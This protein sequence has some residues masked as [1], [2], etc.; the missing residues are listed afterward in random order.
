MNKYLLIFAALVLAVS[1]CEGNLG[2]DQD[3]SGQS[4]SGQVDNNDG[5]GGS[6]NKP[7]AEGNLVARIVEEYIYSGEEND[8][9]SRN[10][11]DFTY[12]GNGNVTKITYDDSGEGL[13]DDIWYYEF[14]YDKDKI[15]LSEI[16]PFDPGENY[17]M[18]FRLDGDGNIELFEGIWSDGKDGVEKEWG[19]VRYDSEGYVIS[20]EYNETGQTP[21]VCSAEWKNGNL[22]RIK[23]EF[24]GAD[25]EYSN[26]D[27]TNSKEKINLDLGWM[28]SESESYYLFISES[29]GMMGM[30]GRMGC[31]SRLYMTKEYDKASW[32]SDASYTYEYDEQGRPVKVHKVSVPHSETGDRVKK[33]TYTITYK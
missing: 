5:Q 14:K 31:R 20:G 6:G 12:D 30:I 33:T 1:G 13:E 17:E 3:G 19:T 7:S 8:G 32:G 25:M 24:A 9:V 10:I 21:D 16:Y 4:G 23:D 11:M 28:I 27:F 15:I 2:D 22:V 18:E 29:C 26:P